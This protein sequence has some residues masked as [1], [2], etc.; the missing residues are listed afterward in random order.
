[1]IRKPAQTFNTVAPATL[2]SAVASN[3]MKAVERFLLKLTQVNGRDALGRTPLMIAARHGL[4]GMTQVLL[5]NGADVHAV[6]KE[7]LSALNHVF[8]DE[9][10]AQQMTTE[11]FIVGML[12]E[13][14]ADACAIIGT[15]PENIGIVAAEVIRRG[16]TAVLGRML[17]NGLNMNS[18]TTRST[19]VMGLQP[20][21]PLLVAAA[22]AGNKQMVALLLARGAGVNESHAGGRTA[23]SAAI[24]HSDLEMVNMVLDAGADTGASTLIDVS[25]KRMTDLEFSKMSTPE[26]ASAVSTAARKFEVNYAA[27]FGQ[28]AK[29]E[30]LLKDRLPTETVDMTG[31]TPLQHAIR[32]LKLDA[33]K[34]LIKYR[35]K[36]NHQRVGS[37]LPL[38]AAIRKGDP[39][40]LRAL[41]EGGASAILTSHGGKDA[42]DVALKIKNLRMWNVLEPYYAY[43]KGVA[44]K[45]AI[46]LN[47]SVAAPQTARFRKAP[48]P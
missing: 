24:A 44:V 3:D 15:R 23:L 30:E 22:D 47:G 42:R 26:I 36:L 21:T 11:P 35:A 31:N 34:V 5:M 12:L 41:L 28:T 7:G 39:D 17:D 4:P 18:R 33:V 1:M 25:G 46:G 2:H 29:L 10:I 32:E 48:T 27:C 20:E 13:R 16:M 37:T 9:K 19:N 6:D 14:G 38:H 8:P 40:V 43:E 45:Q